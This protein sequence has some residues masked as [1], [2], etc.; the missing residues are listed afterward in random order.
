MNTKGLNFSVI[1]FEALSLGTAMIVSDY[2]LKLQIFQLWINFATIDWIGK[3][4]NIL[5]SKG[6]NE[7]FIALQ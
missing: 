6:K 1:S 5:V 3:S 4:T 2:K 7:L